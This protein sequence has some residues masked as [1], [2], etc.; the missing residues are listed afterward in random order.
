MPGW[1]VGY[2]PEISAH[3][4][5]RGIPG[6]RDLLLIM[7]TPEDRAPRSLDEEVTVGLYR[8]DGDEWE[9][10]D[11]LDFDDVSSVISMNVFALQRA[12]EEE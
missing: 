7:T 11:S 6:D 5:T 4:A 3:A 10:I 8:F 12:I 1:S 2:N 9:L